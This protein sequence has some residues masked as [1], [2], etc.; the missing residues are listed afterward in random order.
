[1]IAGSFWILAA[2]PHRAAYVRNIEAN[3]RVRVMVG[4]QWRD[5]IAHLLT[6]DNARRRMLQI[7]PMNGLFIAIAG[8]EHLTIRVDLQR[9]APRPG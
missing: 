4:R 6:E 9:A 5:G 2:D 3:H 1:M 8:R 7:N